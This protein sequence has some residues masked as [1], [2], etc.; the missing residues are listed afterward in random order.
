MFVTIELS[1][2]EAFVLFPFL[3]FER[4]VWFRFVGFS[5]GKPGVREGFVALKC[6]SVAAVSPTHSFTHSISVFVLV[7]VDFLSRETTRER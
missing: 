5:G 4:F 1:E 3:A 2:S 6:G 7:S